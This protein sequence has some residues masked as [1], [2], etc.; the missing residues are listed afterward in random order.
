MKNGID[1][2]HKIISADDNGYP[3]FVRLYFGAPTPRQVRAARP[4]ASTRA[5]IL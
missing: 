3:A 4:K 1:L 2:E 5:L